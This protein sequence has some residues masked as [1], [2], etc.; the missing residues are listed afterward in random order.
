MMKRNKNYLLGL[1][2]MTVLA[3]TILA[4]NKFLEAVPDTSKVI[5]S[6]LED[7]DAMLWDGYGLNGGASGLIEMGTDDYYL[8]QSVFDGLGIFSQQV[9]T[10]EKGLE[11]T[12]SNI[13]QHWGSTY[14]RVLTA[15]VVLDKLGSIDISDQNKA[16]RLKG[17]ALFIRSLAFFQFSQLFM[18]TYDPKTANDGLGIPLKL[19]SDINEK[20]Y[21]STV[22]QTYQRIIDDLMLAK[23]LLSP[24]VE[25]KTRP[26]LPAVEGLLAKVYLL[27]GDFGMAEKWASS[28]LE[29]YSYLSDY[30]KLDANV[31]QPFKRLSDEIVY[32]AYTGATDMLI[33]YTTN[34]D[35]TLV[36]QYGPDDLRR[37]FFFEFD[38]EG[39]ATFRGWYSGINNCPFLGINTAEN[40]LTKAEC[41][42]RKGFYNEAKNE[43][44]T[45]LKNR[46]KDGKVGFIDDIGNDDL[47]G[48]ILKERRKELIFRGTRWSDLRRLNREGR[49]TTTLYRSLTVN[50]KNQLISLA[51]NDKRYI[52]P[53][54]LPVVELSGIAQNER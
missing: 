8:K 1:A 29:H 48:Y 39:A 12:N 34:V 37:A 35:S 21:R 16:N 53:I 36:K 33:S 20:V 22:G 54:P 46:F 27:M 40:Y 11:I 15:N 43:L 14:K 31:A 23:D 2:L 41:L 3:T 26:T 42:A 5:P 38:A 7:L 10:W 24:L 13:N 51:P 19:S 45:L 9:Y 4:C 30:N 6:T 28:S 50:G 32:F 47:L 25:Y 17:E 52:Y 49:Y 44:K 18:D